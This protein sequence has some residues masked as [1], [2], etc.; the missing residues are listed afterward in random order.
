M[1]VVKSIL[2]GTVLVAGAVVAF[3]V[4]SPVEVGDTVVIAAV[5]V[6]VGIWVLAVFGASRVYEDSS[7][8]RRSGWRARLAD[9]L[10]DSRDSFARLWR[11]EPRAVAACAALM[12]LYWMLYP[13]LGV[14][15]LLAAGWSGGEWAQVFLV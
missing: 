4:V 5:A 7:R 3:L 14:L 12:T 15:A 9:P 13:L 8:A 6:V 2:N 11:R 10:R 1:V